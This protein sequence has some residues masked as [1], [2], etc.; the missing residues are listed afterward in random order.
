MKANYISEGDGFPFFFQHGLGGN[1]EQP[2]ALLRN[3]KDIRFISMD[4]HGHG[5]TLFDKAEN[6][7]FK[8]FADDL[9]ALADVLKIEKAAYGGVSMGAGIALNVAIR[10]SERVKALVLVR[11]AWIDQENPG[12]LAI[13]KKLAELAKAGNAE[14]IVDTA[15]YRELATSQPLAAESVLGQV[16][17]EQNEH[18]AV[19]LERM[20][21]DRPFTMGSELQMIKCPVLILASENDAMHPFTI[22]KNLNKRIP[23]SKLVEVPSRYLYNEAHQ[24]AITSQIMAFLKK[25]T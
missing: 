8:Q 13:L 11:P 12:N 5:K 15:E 20:I 25:I 6:I 7:S 2:R 24:Y 23:N 16:T 22:A 9:I 14:R 19:V 21:G 3:L 17:R 1:L 18:T 4:A 10:Y